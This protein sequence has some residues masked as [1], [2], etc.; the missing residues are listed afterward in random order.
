MADPPR[1]R[2]RHGGGLSAAGAIAAGTC[3]AVCLIGCSW[4]CRPA[5]WIAR[6]QRGEP[7][8]GIRDSARTARCRIEVGAPVLWDPQVESLSPYLRT[9]A[10]LPQLLGKISQLR[11]Q[12]TT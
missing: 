3:S 7:P 5:E 12:S 8:T 11:N 4:R 9:Q 1:A 6:R 2:R 10:E